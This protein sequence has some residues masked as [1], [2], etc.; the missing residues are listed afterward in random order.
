MP[1]PSEGPWA[2]TFGAFVGV[3][4]N[5]TNITDD[6]VSGNFAGNEF[7]GFFDETSQTLTFSDATLMSQGRV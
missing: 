1:L 6:S 2:I 3:P 7:S 5:F 4:L